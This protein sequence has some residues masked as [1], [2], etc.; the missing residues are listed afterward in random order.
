MSLRTGIYTIAN[1]K[2]P[3]VL[4][5]ADGNSANNTRILGWPENIA[6]SGIPFLNQLW[7]VRKISGSNVYSL[8]NLGGGTYMDMSLDSGSDSDNGNVVYGRQANDGT[9]DQPSHKANQQWE[10]IAHNQFYK[11]RN[12]QGNTF[13]DLA[14]GGTSGGTIIQTWEAASLNNVS[15]QL[16][17]FKAHGEDQIQTYEE[18]SPYY[19]V[20]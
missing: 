9:A 13:L 20:K 4:D 12:V 11:L 6:D 8:Q 19:A 14:A 5:L 3:L 15:N 1:Q 17:T 18:A 10:I 2:A 16:W 7:L